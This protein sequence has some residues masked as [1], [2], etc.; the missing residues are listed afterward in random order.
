METSNSQYEEQ[1][2]LLNSKI[3]QVLNILRPVV[4]EVAAEEAMVEEVLEEKVKTPKKSASK[5]K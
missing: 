3:D 4:E 2:A 1:F 5:K